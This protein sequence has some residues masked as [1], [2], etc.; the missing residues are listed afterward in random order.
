MEIAKIHT[1]DGLYKAYYYAVKPLLAHV[2][3]ELE[4]FPVAILNEIRSLSCIIHKPE[5]AQ[6]NEFP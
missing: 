4:E 6:K 1:I 2:E 3:S 5:I